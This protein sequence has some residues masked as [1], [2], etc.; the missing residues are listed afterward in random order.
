MFGIEI[1]GETIVPRWSLPNIGFTAAEAVQ[2]AT[3]SGSRLLVA[4]AGSAFRLIEARDGKF[5]TSV[6][7]AA[8]IDSC[9]RSIR[10]IE[11]EADD[12]I[13]LRGERCS[14]RRQAMP[15]PEALAQIVAGIA[16]RIG[17]PPEEF[18]ADRPLLHGAKS[19]EP[20]WFWPW[21]TSAP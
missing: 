14:L 3:Q 18:N 6:M 10:A 21:S 13:L 2:V 19:S 20:S 5:L 11:I 7:S 16:D 9:I 15:S 4:H 8:A 1:K 12:A 17:T